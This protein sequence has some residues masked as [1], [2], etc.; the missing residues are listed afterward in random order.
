MQDFELIK[1][2]I[3]EEDGEKGL[4]FSFFRVSQITKVY[5]AC[6]INKFVF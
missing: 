3:Q 2:V 5:V 1:I 4:N 6:C